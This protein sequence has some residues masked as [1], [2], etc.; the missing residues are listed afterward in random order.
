MENKFQGTCIGVFS[1]NK[2]RKRKCYLY[3]EN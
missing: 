1:Y 3:E 2:G